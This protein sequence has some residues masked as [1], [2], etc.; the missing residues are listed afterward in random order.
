MKIEL[1][2]HPENPEFIKGI[3]IPKITTDDCRN[4]YMDI[5]YPKEL[6]LLKDENYFLLGTIDFSELGEPDDTSE[7]NPFYPYE[8]VSRVTSGCYE[9]DLRE[10]LK[11][12]SKYY[13]NMI[14][15]SNKAIVLL[16]EIKTSLDR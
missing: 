16:G 12:Y 2:R 3:L 8:L 7:K 10:L 9:K 15:T 4:S 1:Y 13:S 5:E 14:S 6:K 11:T